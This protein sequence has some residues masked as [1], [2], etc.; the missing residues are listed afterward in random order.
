VG[1]MFYPDLIQRF[2]FFPI[3]LLDRARALEEGWE[4]TDP[5]VAEGF[6]RFFK[7]TTWM[8]D[9]FLNGTEQETGARIVTSTLEFENGEG[10]GFA[11]AVDGVKMMEGKEMRLSTAVHARARFTYFSPARR[12]PDGN[13]V[14]DGGYYD[15]S[16]AET[17]SDVLRALRAKNWPDV[18]PIVIAI[19]NGP[20]RP[21][22]SPAEAA[23]ATIAL[24]RQHN[25][26]EVTAPLDTML[27]ICSAHADDALAQLRSTLPEGMFL[28][29]TLVERGTVLPLGW[30]LSPQAMAEMDFQVD[31]Q[32][33]GN[34]ATWNTCSHELQAQLLN[35]G[36]KENLLDMIPEKPA[37]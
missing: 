29:F 30:T 27:I 22:P 16:G 18:Q 37:Q 33:A 10:G 19:R 13:H 25:D 32:A 35:S 6:T 24:R 23:K 2:L 9:L 17:V 34:L 8:P 5:H 26:H 20:E 15:N 21:P 31:P 14:A 12:Y 28:S 36:T 11:D 7:A 1:K 4:A 3:P